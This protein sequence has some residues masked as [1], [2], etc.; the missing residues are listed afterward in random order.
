M[1]LGDD[2]SKGWIA[3]KEMI[4]RGKMNSKRVL[5]GR[6]IIES[7]AKFKAVEEVGNDVTVRRKRL[8]ENRDM[9]MVFKMFWLVLSM[10]SDDP[11][12]LSGDG[13]LQLDIY[14]QRALLGNHFSEADCVKLADADYRYDVARFGILSERVFSDSLMEL[15]G[16]RSK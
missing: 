16:E 13:Y 5:I 9:C 14:I 11:L 7:S 3:L 8:I 12:V 4:S 1:H 10:Y 15:I 6:K 2:S